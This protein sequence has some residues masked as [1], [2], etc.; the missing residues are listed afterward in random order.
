MLLVRVF[1]F[2]SL[3]DPFW[4]ALAGSIIAFIYGLPDGGIWTI[5]EVHR[6]EIFTGML[7]YDSMTVFFRMFLLAFAF[8][9]IILVRITG[10]ADK[11]DGQDFY[12]LL[13]GSTLGMCLMASANHLMTVFLSVEMASVPSYVLAGIIKGRRRSSEASLKYAVYGAGDAGVMLYGI[14]LLAGLVGSAH[15]PTIARN[16]AAMD[17]PGMIARHEG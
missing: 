17:I 16:L 12:T 15:F 3:L 4:L 10:L 8:W 11:Q 7:V 9:F 13:L 6:Q 5:G 14:S 1:R 2:G